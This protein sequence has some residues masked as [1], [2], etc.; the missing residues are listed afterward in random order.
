M[1]KKSRFRFLVDMQYSEEE[2][3][4]NEWE[5]VIERR[6]QSFSSC[7]SFLSIRKSLSYEKLPPV[8]LTLSILKLD[9]SSFDVE[10]PRTATVGELKQAI[11][12]AFDHF[13]NEG[14]GKISWSHVWGHFC[15]SYD[16]QN[17]L[18]E[19][20]LLRD[21]GIADGDQLHFF[22]HVS[23]NYNRIKRQSREQLPTLEQPKRQAGFDNAE[24]E[25][26]I[27]NDFVD[28]ES[29]GDQIYDED[30]HALSIYY[31]M[32]FNDLLQNW[33]AYS[34]LPRGRKA[35]SQGKTRTSR[36]IHSFFRKLGK[37]VG[38]RV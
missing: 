33:F 9:G 25:V 14:P 10:V 7:S 24:D 26:K 5:A 21:F 11:E 38:L 12:E 34:S 32:K 1:L 35:N 27:D 29:Q 20:E 17:L 30:S 13:P 8:P 3:S 2:E 31:D 22:Q 18:E 16:G 28:L 19:N 15:L 4:W 36:F 6:R 37:M 23:S